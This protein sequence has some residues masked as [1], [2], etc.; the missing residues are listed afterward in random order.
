ML[1][2]VEYRDYPQCC[3]KVC[4]ENNVVVTWFVGIFESSDELAV[5]IWV[6]AE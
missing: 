1:F 4:W 3:W 2:L 6:R 5:G